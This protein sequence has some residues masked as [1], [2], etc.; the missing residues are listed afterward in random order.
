MTKDKKIVV[1]HDETTSATGDMGLK[2]TESL[3]EDVRKVDVGSHKGEKYKGEKIPFIQEILR[4]VP[5]D[6]KLFVEIKHGEKILPEL[7]PILTRPE[8]KPN[9]VIIGFGFDTMAKAKEMM[10]DVPVYWLRSREKDKATGQYKPYDI[11]LITKA[12]EKNLDGLNLN[13]NGLTEEYVKEIK[14]AGLEIYVWTVDDEKEAK[15]LRDIGVRGIT[16][17]KPDIIRAAVE[18]K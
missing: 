7:V 11:S 14:K 18:N 3:S 17:N 9:I 10:P 16:T 5:K 15:R 8:I 6:K 4:L 2:V 1:I 13:N 12:K